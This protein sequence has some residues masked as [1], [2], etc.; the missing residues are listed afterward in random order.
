MPQS[1]AAQPPYELVLTFKPISI[2]LA[3]AFIVFAIYKMLTHPGGAAR[4][5]N[6]AFDAVV[7][8]LVSWLDL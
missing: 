6:A 7:M 5:L 1:N 4:G 8:S 3:A 2:L